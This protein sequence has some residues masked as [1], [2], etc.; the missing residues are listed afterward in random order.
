M[1]T[2]PPRQR[3]DVEIENAEFRTSKAGN[4]M[5]V[6]SATDKG[7]SLRWFGM[8]TAA[9]TADGSTRAAKTVETLRA[10]GMI[11]QDIAGII[12][13][14]AAFVTEAEEDQLTGETRR[15]VAFVNPAP[16]GAEPDEVAAVFA[17]LGI[18]TAEPAPPAAGEIP[19]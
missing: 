6:I 13:Q 11:G 14:R 18:A 3:V 1:K 4:L 12:G 15:R 17:A 16:K 5:A 2:P 19:F 10:V 8:M 7:E 9:P